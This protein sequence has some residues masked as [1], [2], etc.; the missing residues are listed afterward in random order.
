MLAPSHAPEFTRKNRSHDEESV[1]RGSP[2]SQSQDDA[3]FP[4]RPDSWSE[5][6]EDNRRGCSGL[7]LGESKRSRLVSWRMQYGSPLAVHPSIF[8]L[9]RGLR[10]QVTVTVSCHVAGRNK[11][12]FVVAG[13]IPWAR[14]FVFGKLRTCDRKAMS[15]RVW[16][17]GKHR[18]MKHTR[19]CRSMCVWLC[20][21]RC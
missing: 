2:T 7:G 11:I 18:N 9:L 17:N 10:M 19:G 21:A 1:E 15:D 4:A 12:C 6:V 5:E 8:E 3:L 20:P 16:G 13:P 14:I